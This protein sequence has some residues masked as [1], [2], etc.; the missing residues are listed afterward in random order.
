MVSSKV[1]IALLQETYDFPVPETFLKLS[2][3]T[4]YVDITIANYLLLNMLLILDP[5]FNSGSP[6]LRETSFP[7]PSTMWELPLPRS[8]DINRDEYPEFTEPLHHSF[9]TAFS[10]EHEL[11]ASFITVYMDRCLSVL[12]GWYAIMT[13]STVK[14]RALKHYSPTDLTGPILLSSTWPQLFSCA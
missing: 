9:W 5:N 12:A 11:E 1:S 3:L 4:S 8:N 14:A 7:N 2:G 6:L 13:D 10:D